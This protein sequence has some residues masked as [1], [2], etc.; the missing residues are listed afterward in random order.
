M[1]LNNERLVD[2]NTSKLISA[3]SDFISALFSS[4][5]VLLKENERNNPSRISQ[6]L[7]VS[8]TS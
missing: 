6:I 7:A 5:G 1:N 2:P 3:I 8:E 4:N